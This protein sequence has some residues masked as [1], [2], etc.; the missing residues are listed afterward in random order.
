M[1]DE[2]VGCETFE[3]L[4]SSSEIVSVDEV[5]KVS[6]QLVVVVVVEAFDGGVLDGSVHPLHLPIRPRMIDLGEPVLDAVLVTDPI[7]D[8]VKRVFMAGV[9]CELNAVVRQHRV[10]GVRHSGDEIAEKLGGDHL[11]RFL[12]Q[13][14]IGE[15]GC[16]VDGH[17]QAQLTFGRLHLCD[18]DVEG[19][20]GIA[21]EL[22]FRRFVAFDLRKTA[23]AVSLE[24]AMQGRP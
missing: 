1:A 11:T 12:M 13:V 18:V 20:D 8:V 9:V 15:L 10:D 24:A 2:L 3:G 21:L 6:A 22:L 5:L 17:E 16:P 4:Q 14:G 7:E 23:D 19:T